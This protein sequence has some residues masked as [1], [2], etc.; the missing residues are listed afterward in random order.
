VLVSVFVPGGWDSLSVLAPV[1]D[2]KYASYRPTLGLDGATTTPFAE[3]P[4]LHWH[5]SAAALAAL[6]SE[7]KVTV[8]PG[9]GYDHPDQ[10]HF[11]SRHYWEVGALDPRAG[12]G[13][14]GRY[15]EHA[16]EPDNPLQGLSLDSYLS[17]ALA[18]ASV[19][20]AAVSNPA[21][22]GMYVAGVNK[23]IVQPMLSAIA[24][25]GRI[26]TADHTLGQARAVA[27]RVDRLRTDLTVLGDEYGRPVYNSPVAYPS[28]EFAGRLAGL[29]AMVGAGLPLRCVCL[30]APGL[31]DTHANQAYTLPNLLQQ[32]CDAL[33]AFQRDVEARGVADRVL[34]KVWSEFGRRAPE[35][36]SGT[37]HGAA[38][39]AFLLG[40]RVRGQMIGQFPGL[41]ALDAQQN[42]RA[43]ADFRALYCSLLEQW[44]DADAA[45]V[46]P[47][48]SGFGRYALLN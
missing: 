2:P 29:A 10:S 48:A 18:T 8:V 15:L 37:D 27:T 22:Y 23:P 45:A 21:N 16:G 32:T 11:T 1:G 3:D 38:G 26:P 12:L 40:T 13:W 19:P 5:P 4:A 9:I 44:L 42:L 35:N 41:S 39:L 34:V 14:M 31:Y 25:L 17:P 36:G 20:V 24:D 30:T 46:M 43:T 6:H 47:G 33:L 7:G 28:G